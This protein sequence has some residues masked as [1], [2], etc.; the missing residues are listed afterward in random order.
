MSLHAP[1]VP[2]KMHSKLQILIGTISRKNSV[3]MQQ[4]CNGGAEQ[5]VGWP[6]LPCAALSMLDLLPSCSHTA[7]QCSVLSPAG[8]LPLLWCPSPPGR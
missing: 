3:T 7:I 6:S 1:D 2:L 8:P 4:H 5:G